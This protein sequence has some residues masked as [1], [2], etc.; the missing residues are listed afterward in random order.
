MKLREYLKEKPVDTMT[1]PSMMMQVKG[2]KK[3]GS[4]VI[5]DK[6]VAK[7]LMNLSKRLSRE[8]SIDIDKKL[9]DKILKLYPYKDWEKM[10]PTDRIM[11]FTTPEWIG[12]GEKIKMKSGEVVTLDID[13]TLTYTPSTD[14][15][16]LLEKKKARTFSDFIRESRPKFIPF[17]LRKTEH[18]WTL[19][20]LEDG[21][22]IMLKQFKLNR[23]K[24]FLKDVNAC[25]SVKPIT[26]GME[27]EMARDELINNG[28][29]KIYIPANRINYM[30]GIYNG[31]NSPYGNMKN[32]KF[33]DGKG[34]DADKYEKVYKY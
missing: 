23:L 2:G 3:D 12:K 33:N 31:E 11:T 29:I 14:E 15:M 24:E 1:R 13:H 17:R 20:N 5:Q 27:Y 26:H 10:S 6:S 28:E 21:K 19:K 32:Y 9:K 34:Y 7:E 16:V 8:F 22:L 4:Y 25:D 30:K 18:F